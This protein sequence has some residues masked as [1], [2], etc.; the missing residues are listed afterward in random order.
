MDRGDVRAFADQRLA[1]A[2]VAEPPG[3][4]DRR[5]AELGDRAGERA[6]VVDGGEGRGPEARVAQERL[7]DEPVL[8]QRERPR[9][10][11]APERARFRNSTVA[12]GT[13]S[14]S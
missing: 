5:A 11:A 12:V 4:Q 13:F 14:N 3:L 7:F 6:G 10:R 9:A 2:V 1:L 8:G